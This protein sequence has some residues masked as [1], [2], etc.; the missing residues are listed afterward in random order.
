[1]SALTDAATNALR[2]LK[3]AHDHYY[4]HVLCLGRHLCPCANAIAELEAELGMAQIL[5]DE[6][7]KGGERFLNR[8]VII[9]DE[10]ARL[11]AP[12]FNKDEIKTLIKLCH[13]DRHMSSDAAQTITRKLL[14]M[15]K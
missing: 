9:S 6:D 2:E 4:P 3:H 12:P 11:S 1:M 5:E 7:P 14:E 10:L 13:E 8:G 15:R